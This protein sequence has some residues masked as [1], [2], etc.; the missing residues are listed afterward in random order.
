MVLCSDFSNEVS[1]TIEAGQPEASFSISASTGVA[2]HTATFSNTSTGTIDTYAWEFGDGNTSA[3]QSPQH[4]YVEAGVYSV[5]LTVTGPGGSSTELR[6]A[7][8]TVQQP[9]PVAEFKEDATQGH[10]P[11]T[12][13]FKDN[14]AGLIDTY[15]WDFGDGNSATSAVAVHTFTNPGTYS[16]ALKVEGPG[17]SSTKTKENLVEVFADPPTADFNASVVSGTAPLS[18]QFT[19]ASQGTVSDYHWSFGDGSSSLLANPFHT[20]EEPGQYDVTL[21]VTGPGGS[22]LLTRFGYIQVGGDEVPLETGEIILDHVWQRV[23]F[24]R[25][26]TNPVVILAPLSHNGGDPAFARIESVD[27]TGFHVRVQ[28]WDYLDDWHTTETLGYLVIERGQHELPDGSWIEADLIELDGINGWIPTALSAPFATAPIVLSNVM[29]HNDARAVTTRM[30][31]VGAYGFEIALQGEEA[32]TVA[33]G[34]ESVAYLAWEPSVGEI[35]GLAFEV[36]R[37]FD[38][39][40][41]A[42]HR[43][44]FGQAFA[45]PPVLFANMQSTD[46]GD[47]ANLRWDNKG[48]YSADV[49]VDEEQSHD[50]EIDHTSET[51]GY[52]AIEES[53]RA[54]PP[55]EVGSLNVDSDWQWVT[56]TKEFSEP[57]IVAKLTSA[58]DLDPAVVRIDGLNS[59]GFW[60]RIQEWDYLDD[61]HTVEQV[62]YMVV[63]KGRHKMPNGAWLEAGRIET[64]ATNAFI[65][66]AY[67][68]RFQA[69]PVVL[70]SVST[71]QGSQ[72]VTVRLRNISQSGFDVTMEEQEA[73]PQDHLVEAIDYIAIEASSGEWAGLPFEVGRT[74]NAVTHVRYSIPLM[75]SMGDAG[76]VLADM[77]TTDGGDTASVRTEVFENSVEVWIE[78]E[79]SLD[80]EIA[81]T[82]ETVGYII[83]GASAAH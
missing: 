19:N 60:I 53:P 79:Q 26:F 67:R 17:G 33:H 12:I 56:L 44:G 65:P 77:Q 50:S 22:D 5:S 66:V 9:A 83:M 34:A 75:E 21:K 78:E 71:Y 72:A 29:T 18:V 76:F 14:S 25:T 37:T 47:T 51:V 30:R 70:T 48:L 16:V 68:T 23:D 41:Q 36:G 1:T 80:E 6:P 20:Y 74:A 73:S 63:E 69:E 4:T 57:V 15:F 38:E 58:V 3:E 49:W 10:A 11:L 8:V 59:E 28:E 40:T 39:V 27:S 24:K 46:G 61:V 2:P 52:L 7:A 62:S 54:A 82:T 81:H 64:D 42:P 35:N 31:S 32:S 13:T 43:L 55:L 45:S